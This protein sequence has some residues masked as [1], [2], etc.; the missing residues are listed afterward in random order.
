MQGSR[1]EKKWTTYGSSRPFLGTISV[2]VGYFYVHRL[3]L[4]IWYVSIYHPLINTHYTL[5]GVILSANRDNFVC[6]WGGGLEIDLC[7]PTSLLPAP[8]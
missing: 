4:Y 8:S 7:T 5:R 2:Y 3:P 1:P 6:G